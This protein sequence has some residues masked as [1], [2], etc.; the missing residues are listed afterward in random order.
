MQDTEQQFSTP[1]IT[2]YKYQVSHSYTFINS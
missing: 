1:K 2:E